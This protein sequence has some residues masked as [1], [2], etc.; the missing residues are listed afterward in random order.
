MEFVFSLCL[1]TFHNVVPPA[2]PPGSSAEPAEPGGAAAAAAA[3]AL[4]E[5]AVS[6]FAQLKVQRVG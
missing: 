2:E 4:L 3:T 6:S 5:L 1:E